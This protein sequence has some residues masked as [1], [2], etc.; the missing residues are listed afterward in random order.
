MTLCRGGGGRRGQ[1]GRV[2]RRRGALVAHHDRLLEGD[3]DAAAGGVFDG[4][5]DL[6]VEVVILQAATGTSQG[7]EV[8]AGWG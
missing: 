3:V 5:F 7:N 1:L 6:V 4:L 8:S 2:G